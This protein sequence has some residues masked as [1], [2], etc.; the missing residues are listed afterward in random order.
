MYHFSARFYSPRLGRFL[1][2]DTIVPDPSNPQDL[3]RF[4]YVRNNPIK[5]IDPTGHIACIDFD[6]NEGCIRD[7]EWRPSGS[8][9]N[10]TSTPVQD[11]KKPNIYIGVS[12]D[13]LIEIYIPVSGSNLINVYLPVSGDN[14]IDT[15]VPVKPE[16]ISSVYTSEEPEF[17]HALQGGE[18]NNYVYIGYDENGEAIYAGIT[19]NIDRRQYEHRDRFDIDP[20]ND[21]PLTRGQVRAIEQAL[22]VNNRFDEN[23]RN[24]I[25]PNHPYYQPAVDWGNWW[26]D[27]NGQTLF[28]PNNEA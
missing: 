5:Y 16:D 11:D 12:D 2:A 9:G 1:S 19:N 22:I 3:N 23:Q 26:L 28:L 6:R 21:S 10:K 14:L 13:N 18:S 27:E 4:S 24:S 15:Y 7:P 17:P 20:L 8:T 25:S